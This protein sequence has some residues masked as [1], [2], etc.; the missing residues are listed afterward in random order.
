MAVK[1]GDYIRTLPDIGARLY[2][3]LQDLEQ[4]HLT[5]AQQVNGSGEGQPSAPPAPNTLTVTAKNGHFQAAIQDNGPIYRGIQY[6]LEH[7][8]NPHFINPHVEHLGPSR[9]ANLFLG[10]ATRYFRA[11]SS[12]S[13]SPPSAPVYHGG[14]AKPMPVTGGG[15]VGPPPFLDS[16]GSGTGAAG[17]GLS[18][19]GPV[20]FRSVSGVAPKR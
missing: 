7:A 1:N 15:F 13:S 2:E 19:P 14:Q 12:Y 9:N 18:G 4:R 17:V 10:S 8:D 6:H 11:Y 5:L 16:Q 20:P 3:A